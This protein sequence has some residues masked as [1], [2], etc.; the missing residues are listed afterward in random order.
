[1]DNLNDYLTPDILAILGNIDNWVEE[2]FSTIC[3]VCGEEFLA[4]PG[5][6]RRFYI[7]SENLESVWS[8]SAHY[9]CAIIEDQLEN[10]IDDRIT[11]WMEWPI[12]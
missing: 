5:E 6:R 12:H 11:G 7:Y 2:G 1:M 10:F 4:D 9:A 8:L 3:A